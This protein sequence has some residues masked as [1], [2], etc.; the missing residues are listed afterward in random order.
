MAGYFI[1]IKEI[2]LDSRIKTNI[3]QILYT[4]LTKTKQKVTIKMSSSPAVVAHAFNPSRSLS[5]K[6][7]WSTE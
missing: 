4:E 5:S 6:P 3:S 2:D 1:R 7:V